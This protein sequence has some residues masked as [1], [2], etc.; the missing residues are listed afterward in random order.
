M[1]LIEWL[2]TAAPEETALVNRAA[3]PASETHAPL[4]ETDDGPDLVP[5]PNDDPS[6][7]IEEVFCIIDYTDAK[8][9][10]TRRRIT[11]R[12]IEATAHG[13]CIRA[14]CHERRAIRR[15][16]LD[17]IDGVIDGDGVVHDAT[18]FLTNE[19]EIDPALL[20]ADRDNATSVARTIRDRLRPALSILVI[21]SECD[22]E[23]HPEELDV[24]CI[25]VEDELHDL[26]A[27]D[28]ALSPSI[29]TLDALTRLARRMRPTREALPGYLRS[30]LDMDT[31]RK[32]RFFDALGR[33]ILADGRLAIEE[34]ELAAEIEALKSGRTSNILD[35][36]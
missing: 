15:F 22:G 1:R 32:A 14:I 35:T 4:T 20:G 21:A 23:M 19:I 17:R 9:Q 29:E 3:P 2:F 18:T 24:I 26:A 25:Y 27:H 31:A 33:L 6:R 34:I 30:V 11:M 7:E 8:G 10:T 13:T 16:R 12:A 28:P 5:V 36:H